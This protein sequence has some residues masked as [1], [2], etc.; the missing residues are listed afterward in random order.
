MSLD[1]ELLARIDERVK[2]LSVVVNDTQDDMKD[3]KKAIGELVEKTNVCPLGEDRERAHAAVLTEIETLKNE[4]AELRG[5]RRAL[6][7]IAG[8]VVAI[9]A[10]IIGAVL[11]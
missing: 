3:I 2:V 7:L 5:G 4:Q 10:A 1:N 9:I 11:L 8:A 6:I